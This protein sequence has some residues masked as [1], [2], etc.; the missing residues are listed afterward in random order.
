MSWGIRNEIS[1]FSIW[2]LNQDALVSGNRMTTSDWNN[3]GLLFDIIRILEV[4]S[5]RLDEAGWAS[6]IFL[7]SPLWSQDDCFIQQ[8]LIQVSKIGRMETGFSHLIGHN[9]VTWLPPSQL[10]GNTMEWPWMVQN[11]LSFSPRIEPAFM[12]H[13]A[14]WF[15]SRV[16]A[17]MVRNK[18]E[19]HPES[20]LRGSWLAPY[21]SPYLSLYNSLPIDMQLQLYLIL[22]SPVNLGLFLDFVFCSDNVKLCPQ[23]AF[24]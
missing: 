13:S 17:V 22:H 18:G 4:G 23:T 3:R 12:E 10:F 21:L 9:L 16:L 20:Q 24:V 6:L 11:N 14:V 19:V 15:L 8:L 5:F 7:A 2:L 1:F